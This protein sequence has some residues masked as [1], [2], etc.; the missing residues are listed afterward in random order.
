MTDSIDISV[1]DHK[2]VLGL[3]KQHL[4]NVAVWAYGSRVKW[5]ARPQSDLDL[6]AFASCEQKVAVL[7]LR[8]VLEESSLPFPVDLFIWDEL[9]ESF[10]KRIEAEHVVL[11]EQATN[12]RDTADEWRETTFSEALVI[13]PTVR[14]NR[15]EVYPFV[16]MSA[17]NADSRSANSVEEREFKGSGSRFQN[18]DTL[19]ARITPCLENGKIAR[20]QA[21]GKIQEAH[22]STEFI[23][24]R[25]RPNVTDNNFV[26][27]LTQWED[28][29]N[30]A[31]GQMTGTS[32]R[33][34]VPVDS[35]DHLTVPLPPLPEQ[36]AIA[37]ILDTLDDK[38]ELNRRMNETLEAMARALFKA[39]FVDFEP[40]RAKMEGRDTGLPAKIAALFPD[41]LVESELGEVPEGWEVGCLAEIAGSSRRGMSPSDVSK[42]TPYIGLEHMPRHSIA[43]TQWENAGKVTSSKSAFRK[44]EFLFGKLRPYFHKVGVAPIDGICSTDIIVLLPKSNW[45]SNFVLSCISTD[46]FVAYTDQISTGTRMPRTSWKL[47][48]NYQLCLPSDDVVGSFQNTTQPVIDRIVANIHESRTLA[49]LRDTLLPKLV[50]GEVRVDSTT[51][52][53]FYDIT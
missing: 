48:G 24:I 45:W 20:Y 8:E 18:G 31:I 53:F 39:W 36:R 13:N 51:G 25:G 49:T 47:M 27:Y 2:L 11:Q 28:I 37:H 14:L 17:V 41:R 10:R 34:R 16:D 26:Y 21:L 23:V 12:E 46:E 42:D 6:V 50:S 29:R 35:L 9:P 43:L 30:Y 22:G 3:L 4:P 38:I 7:N 40:V 32:G 5:T 33:Q 44:G 15:G 19:M 52:G 1:D